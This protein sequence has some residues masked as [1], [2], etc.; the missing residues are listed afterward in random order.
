MVAGGA[1]RR[2][3]EEEGPQEEEDEEEDGAFGPDLDMGFMEVLPQTVP[4]Q[5][6]LDFCSMP[7]QLHKIFR[8]RPRLV[9]VVNYP[10]A[11]FVELPAGE[12]LEHFKARLGSALWKVGMEVPM[13]TGPG[14]WVLC[15]NFIKV[16]STMLQQAIQQAGVPAVY[17]QVW[18][19][20][21]FVGFL[22]RVRQVSG[23]SRAS[24]ARCALVISATCAET[25][26]TCG[27]GG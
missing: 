22:R 24:P 20:A 15:K 25:T 23:R 21:T 9:Q 12:D 27:F 6:N 17:R 4:R 8:E 26:R 13:P 11:I 2:A 16:H 5:F 10:C 14:D 1:R 3:R 18:D 19:E 7:G